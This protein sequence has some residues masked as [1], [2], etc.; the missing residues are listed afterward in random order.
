MGDTPYKYM[1]TQCGSETI[2]V[3]KTSHTIVMD[4][5]STALEVS[6]DAIT[7]EQGAAIDGWDKLTDEERMPYYISD[8]EVNEAA[9]EDPTNPCNVVYIN[10]Y[11]DDNY[12]TSFNATAHSDKIESLSI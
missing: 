11:S 7:A 12:D 6:W 4:R 1:Y 8:F 3:S 5:S 9:G 10:A 2:T